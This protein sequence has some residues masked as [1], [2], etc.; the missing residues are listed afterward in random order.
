MTRVATKPTGSSPGLQ[1]TDSPW[2]RGSRDFVRAIYRGDF[3]TRPRRN[4]LQTVT[5]A[6][7]AYEVD[8]VHDGEHE[9]ADPSTPREAG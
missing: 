4:G 9:R 2:N 7:E 6:I 8:Q 5:Q 3:A 1:Q